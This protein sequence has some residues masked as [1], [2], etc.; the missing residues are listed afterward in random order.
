VNTEGAI[1]NWQSRE[2]GNIW[3]TKWRQTN[4]KHNT[5]CAG[6]HYRQPNIYI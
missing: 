3:Y 2:T 6:H 5:I 4:Q 1:Q